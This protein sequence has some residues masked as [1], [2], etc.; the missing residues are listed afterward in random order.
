MVFVAMHCSSIL[1]EQ[2]LGKKPRGW[3]KERKSK[4]QNW[5]PRSGCVN[6]KSCVG[7]KPSTKHNAFH[8]HHVFRA[9]CFHVTVGSS[10]HILISVRGSP[11]MLYVWLAVHSQE[12]DWKFAFFSQSQLLVCLQSRHK[13]WALEIASGKGRSKAEDESAAIWCVS[14]HGK[15]G[16]LSA[17]PNQWHLLET[18]DEKENFTDFVTTVGFLQ[19]LVRENEKKPIIPPF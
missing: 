2:G 12:S 6:M 16:T 10:D 18:D 7:L 4:R 1:A 8:L 19:Y 14:S 5:A 17:G 15:S 13:G 9:A 11:A 3:N